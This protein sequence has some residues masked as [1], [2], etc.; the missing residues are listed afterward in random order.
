[1]IQL[2]TAESFLFAL[3][4]QKATD[5]SKSFTVENLRPQ[6]GG[7]WI[8]EKT[9]FTPQGFFLCHQAKRARAKRSER[10]TNC[11]FPSRTV[12][13]LIPAGKECPTFCFAPLGTGK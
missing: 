10:G 12:E 13:F 9:S 3:Q 1:M 11:G 7:R 6:A 5:G 4:F 2:E 8:V